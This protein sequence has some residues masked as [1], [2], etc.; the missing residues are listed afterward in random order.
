MNAVCEIV[1]MFMSL[2]VFFEIL[3][4]KKGLYQADK[5]ENM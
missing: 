5:G 3:A 1:C 4:Q 2:I